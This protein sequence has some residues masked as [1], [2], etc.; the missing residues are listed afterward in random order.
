MHHAYDQPLQ[1]KARQGKARQG[2]T[3]LDKTRQDKARQGRTKTRQDKARQGKTRQDK[4]RQGKTGRTYLRHNAITEV[5]HVIFKVGSF[6]GTIES[7]L[8]VC[9]TEQYVF[10]LR[11][12]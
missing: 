12:A 3:R 5:S 7:G 1:G 6:H 2:K 10:L 8:I 11:R 9:L 4:A